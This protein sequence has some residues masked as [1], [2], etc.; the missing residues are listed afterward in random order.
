M[1]SRPALPLVRSLRSIARDHHDKLAAV[2]RIVGDDV[3]EETSRW[4]GA[5]RATRTSSTSLREPRPGPAAGLGHRARPRHGPR[6]PTSSGRN[7]LPEGRRGR[8]TLPIFVLSFAGTVF[9]TMIFRSPMFS[10]IAVS[11][12]ATAAPDPAGGQP[13]R[14]STPDLVHGASRLIAFGISYWTPDPRGRLRHR[15][16]PE[17]LASPLWAAGRAKAKFA[18]T[19]SIL[20]RQHADLSTLKVVRPIARQQ[21]G[22]RTGHRRRPLWVEE[23]ISLS[24][25]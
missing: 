2:L 8:P 9:L 15:P 6:Q 25:P 18:R 13:G 21:Q 19:L 4:R 12:A 22:A 24:G 10:A 5:G 16:E 1:I 23:G 3:Q 14:P 17:A 7:L 11:G 20:T